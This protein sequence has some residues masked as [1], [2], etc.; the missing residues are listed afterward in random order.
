M[1]PAERAARDEAEAAAR[2]RIAALMRRPPVA[3]DS[4]GRTTAR[5]V[6]GS[7]R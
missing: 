6:T 1:T 4:A 7:Q 5:H 2:D 3:R